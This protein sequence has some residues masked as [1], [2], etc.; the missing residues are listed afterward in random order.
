[1]MEG[2]GWGFGLGDVALEDEE[3][4]DEGGFEDVRAQ[5]GDVE[6]EGGQEGNGEG[7]V[8]D[9]EEEVVFPPDPGE[10]G[11]AEDE[12]AGDGQE[13]EDH[14]GVADAFEEEGFLDVEVQ[15]EGGVEGEEEEQ[16]AAEGAVVGVEFLVREAGKERDGGVGRFD[17]EQVVEGQLGGGDDAE[18]FGQM[19]VV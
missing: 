10:G 6:V 8:K 12:E 7:D 16:D 19:E 3:G 13:A 5:V 14:V 11:G 17:G 1:G 2:G 4:V 15:V 18:A 9:E